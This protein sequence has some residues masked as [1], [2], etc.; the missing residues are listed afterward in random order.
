MDFDLSPVLAKLELVL[1]AQ[2]LI[3]E[4]HYTALSDEQRKLVLLFVV[5]IV[6]LQAN[7]LSADVGSQV[8]YFLCCAKKS[9]LLRVCASSCVCVLAVIVTNGVHVLK[10]EWTRWTV[11][12]LMLA[13]LKALFG[14]ESV[15][16]SH[17]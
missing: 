8:L 2:I 9:F 13:V 17:C 10:V 7:D 12:W 6:E 14:C 11:L 5:E 1:R 16:G 3:A 4:E 15:L